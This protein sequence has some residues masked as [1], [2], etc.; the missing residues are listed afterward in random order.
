MIHKTAIIDESAKVGEGVT[1]GA[2]SIIAANVEI[3]AGTQ[4][5]PHVVIN[6]PT[7]IGEQNK[8]F[9]FSSIGEAPQDKKYNGEPTRLIVGDRNVIRECVTIN[10]GTV[11]G[12][13]KTVIGS[14]N[15]FMASC[16][17]AHDCIVGNNTT[18][19]NYAALAGHVEVDD[20]AILGGFTAVHQFTRIG[21]HSLCGLG[22]VVSQ[23]ILPFST[24]VG[25]RARAIGINKEGLRRNGFAEDLIVALHQAFRV[26]IKSKSPRQD[27][28]EKLQSLCAKYPEVKECVDFI[29]QSKRGIAQ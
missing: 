25:D 16:H 5:G 4:V 21:R 6:G 27:A 15:L 20:F 18:F 7:C 28:F 13:G 26:L 9:Q 8:I 14:G 29:K 23:D 19:A 24:A 12:I 3:G 2:Y 1:V 17:V 11:S 10:R 22:S